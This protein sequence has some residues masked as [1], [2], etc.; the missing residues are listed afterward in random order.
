M[1]SIIKHAKH[2]RRIA[3]V[4]C[5]NFYASCERVFQPAWEQR[6]VGVLSNND[7]C[8]IARSNELKEAGIPMGAPYFKYKE[9]LNAMGAIVVSSNY[10]LY[11]DLSARVMNTLGS[12]TPNIEIYS[13][14]EAW[15]DLT[16]FDPA[17]LDAYGRHIVAQTKQHTGIPVSMGIASTKVLAKIA[18]RICKKRKIPGHVFNL[19]SA[20]HI[21]AVLS[22]VPI[23]DVWGIGR[24]WA[25]KLQSQG[26]YTAYDLQQ[27]DPNEMRS[28]YNVL[29]QRL[30]LEL[31]GI[32][33]LDFE[34]IEP[35]KQII[36]SRSFGEKVTMKD[37]LLQAVSLHATRA[38]EKLRLQSS[39]C[40]GIQISL[41]SSR[42]NPNAPYFARS[43]CLS[44]PIATADTRQLIQAA[45]AGV[46]RL[47]QSGIR[48]AKAGIM[49]YDIVPAASVQQTLFEQSEDSKAIRLM[50]TMDRLNRIHGKQTAFFAAEGTRKNW[51]MKRDR[52]T[53][54]FTT[55]WSDLPR[56]S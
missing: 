33:C 3:L 52:M 53:P 24:R 38:G 16:G 48:Y 37:D 1:E 12:F 46:E 13:I 41:R 9:Q 11:G 55:R 28:R 44:F 49:L 18:N 29:M 56:V 43:I 31:R 4:D 15:L 36:A 17:T 45:R 30:I 27:A 32:Q 40:A 5:N 14:D 19:G 21:E 22:S 8:I 47:F 10:T 51:Q 54:A 6:P 20:E 26:I 35:K 2:P 25:E 39:A 50:Q 23:E 7:G 42:F 34:D